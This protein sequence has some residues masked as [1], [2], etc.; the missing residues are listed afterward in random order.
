MYRTRPCEEHHG[1]YPA[2]EREHVH[3]GH[4]DYLIAVLCHIFQI[5]GKTLRSAGYIHNPFRS[6]CDY[7]DFCQAEEYIQCKLADTLMY[8]DEVISYLKQLKI[9]RASCRE[10]V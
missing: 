2:G 10:R 5:P 7:M 1:L 8:K 9:G 3:R 4:L 6:K